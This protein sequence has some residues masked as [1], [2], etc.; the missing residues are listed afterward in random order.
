ML[1]SSESGVL[2]QWRKNGVNITTFKKSVDFGLNLFEEHKVFIHP[3]NMLWVSFR[4][5]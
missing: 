1:L 3:R 4:Q 2:H 5:I